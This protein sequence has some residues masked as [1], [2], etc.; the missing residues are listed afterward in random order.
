VRLGGCVAAELA[1]GATFACALGA[2]ALWTGDMVRS[3]GQREAHAAAGPRASAVEPLVT[4]G[5]LDPVGERLG[6]FQGVSDEVLL[7]PLRDAKVARV[8]VNRGGSSISLRIDFDNGARAAFKPRQTNWQSMPHKEI[9][10]FRIDRLLGLSAVPPAIGRSLPL[11]DI[12]ANLLPDSVFARPRM[13]AE[14]IPDGDQIPGELSWWIPVIDWATI[15]RHRVDQLDGVVTWTRYLTVGVDMPERNRSLLSQISSMLVFDLLIN[16]SDRFSGGNTRVSEDGEVLYFMDNTLSF[17]SSRVGHSKVRAY[18]ER[19]QKFSRSLVAKLRRLET[20]DLRTV[21]EHD[22]G[23][24]AELLTDE[25]IEAVMARRDV[26]LE[27][28][29]RLIEAHGEDAVLVFP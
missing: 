12:Y 20:A 9:A 27:Y 29:D 18:L 13:E 6:L 8:R 1:L 5:R 23:P 22:R 2:A 16:N 25:E 26:A 14:M 19:C 17:G 7:A 10:A 21:L 3:F 4:E 11:G 28:I 24:F 15:D